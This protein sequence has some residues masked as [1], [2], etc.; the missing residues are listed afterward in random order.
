MINISMMRMSAGRLAPV[1]SRRTLC[2]TLAVSRTPSM[3]R[4][5][6]R[7]MVSIFFLVCHSDTSSFLL[8][9]V[10]FRC[11]A[12]QSD[13]QHLAD[14]C[15]DFATLGDL[16]IVE[17]PAVYTIAPHG[18]QSIK[19]TIKVSSM[20]TGVIFGSILWEGQKMAEACIILNNIHI[21]IMDYIKPAYCTEHQVSRIPACI[22]NVETERLL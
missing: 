20:E 13:R 22:P 19:P 12:R 14:L 6:S 3:R 18:F 5:T 2:R 9:T 10:D 16:K 15:L 4:L 17:R 11:F 1:K 8:L 21:D 7:C